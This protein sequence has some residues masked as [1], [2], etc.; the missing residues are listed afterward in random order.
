L[1]ANSAQD[2]QENINICE[3]GDEVS[4]DYDFEKERY[5]VSGSDYIGCLPKKLEQYADAATF[6]IEEIGE[7]DSGKQYVVVGAYAAKG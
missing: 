3:E 6:V 2:A 4:V 1:I 5:E 7:N